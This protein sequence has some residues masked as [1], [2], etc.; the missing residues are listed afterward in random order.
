[1]PRG[2]K[3]N[4]TP[5]PDPTKAV[6]LTFRIDQDLVSHFKAVAALNN[7][8]VEELGKVALDNL[9]KKEKRTF[10]NWQNNA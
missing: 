2:R 8:K 1:M 6:R 4:E 7:M 9:I 5:V 10:Q 3:K